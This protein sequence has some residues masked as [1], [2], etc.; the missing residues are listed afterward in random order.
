VQALNDLATDV[1]CSAAASS[2]ASKLK[3]SGCMGQPQQQSCS[4]VVASD[5]YA[6]YRKAAGQSYW[7]AHYAR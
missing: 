1:S 6:P 2:A 4:P 5:A 7:L 3:F